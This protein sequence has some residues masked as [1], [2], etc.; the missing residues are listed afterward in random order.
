MWKRLPFLGGGTRSRQYDGG[1]NNGANSPVKAASHLAKANL[2][3]AN[4]AKATKEEQKS[5]EVRRAGAAIEPIFGHK[6]GNRYHI[7]SVLGVGAFSKVFA[8]RVISD[9]ECGSLDDSND[10]P[11]FEQVAI[12]VT[13]HKGPDADAQGEAVF[14]KPCEESKSLK[15]QAWMEILCHRRVSGHPNVV[16]FVECV[17]APDATALVMERVSRNMFDFVAARGSLPDSLVRRYGSQLLSAL[18]H[19]HSRGVVHRDVKLENILVSEDGES[20][21]LCDFGLSSFYKPGATLKERCGSP[22]YASPEIVGWRTGY[23]GPEVDAW[24]AG[25]SLYVMRTGTFPFWS[26]DLQELSVVVCTEEP[27]PVPA[28]VPYEFV[29]LISCMLAKDTYFRLTVSQALG[30]PYFQPIEPIKT[31]QR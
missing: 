24:S 2:A 22:P 7:E 8:A 19:V 21:K 23:E 17:M 12:K 18:A 5:G 3:L 26:D 10:R 25:V 31:D 13:R 20:L 1:G 15:D 28:G 14:E 6:P 30:H 27:A 29:H 11:I 9:K 4:F 16:A